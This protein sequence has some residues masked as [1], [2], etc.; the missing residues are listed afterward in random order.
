MPT[1]ARAVIYTR[2]SSVGQEDNYSLETQEAACRAIAVERGW[3]VAGIYRDVHTGTELFERQGLAALRES[4]RA[5]NSTIVLA[6]ALDRLS[7]DQAHLGFLI[8]EWD[9]AGARLELAM[10][11]LDDTPLGRLL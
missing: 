4:V 11:K 2:V 5:G 9:H 10:E 8:S 7:R 3:E 6:Y 1:A